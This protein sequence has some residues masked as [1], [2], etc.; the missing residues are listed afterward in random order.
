M[1]GPFIVKGRNRKKPFL[2]VDRTG[3]GFW[4]NVNKKIAE[5]TLI[6]VKFMQIHVNTKLDQF[7]G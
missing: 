7:E 1:S 6:L 2:D 4:Q 3:I 5:R